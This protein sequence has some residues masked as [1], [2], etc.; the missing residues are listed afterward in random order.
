MLQ[1]TR[2]WLVERGAGSD[3]PDQPKLPQPRE[4]LSLAILS[5]MLFPPCSR[6]LPGLGSSGEKGSGHRDQRVG[7]ENPGGWIEK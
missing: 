7:K 4:P 2:E 6:G 3:E 5:L 1:R